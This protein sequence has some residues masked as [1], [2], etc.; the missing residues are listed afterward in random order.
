MF[1][2]GLLQLVHL[3]DG[4]QQNNCQ[5]S[6]VKQFLVHCKVIEVKDS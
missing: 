1:T 5:Y 4:Y 6:A 3:L 2:T